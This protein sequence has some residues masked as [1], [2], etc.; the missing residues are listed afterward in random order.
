M[1]EEPQFR[2][3]LRGF[4]PDQVRSTLN[5]MQNALTTA[6]RI[7]A[8]RTIE[9]TRMQDRHAQLERDLDEAV[10]RISDLESRA[11][12][13]NASADVGARIGT[14]LALANEEA[15][16]LRAGGRDRKSVV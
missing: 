10:H 5:E 7:A 13:S 3:V 2:T 14:I 11:G 8:D 15:E 9:L 1:T 16:E 6:R 12:L 4:D